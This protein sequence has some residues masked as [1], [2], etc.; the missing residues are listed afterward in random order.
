[1]RA[2]LICQSPLRNNQIRNR[3]ANQNQESPECAKNTVSAAQDSPRDSLASA[4]V[5]KPGSRIRG[6]CA[7]S[8]L[9]PEQVLADDL[10]LE[11]LIHIHTHF[12][13]GGEGHPT[14]KTQLLRMTILTAFSS[15]ICR[16]SISNRISK[17]MM[18]ACFN[19]LLR[20]SRQIIASGRT[21][22]KPS[23]PASG[24]YQQSTGQHPGTG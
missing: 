17:P 7:A 16:R 11:I 15:L 24:K 3:A 20:A 21:D 9:P 22:S 12:G 10:Q 8:V 18:A 23:L 1:M 6:S 19:G 2:A 13:I 5:K 14:G 4:T